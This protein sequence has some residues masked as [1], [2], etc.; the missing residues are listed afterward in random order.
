M[1]VFFPDRPQRIKSNGMVNVRGIKINHVIQPALR[2]KIKHF[3]GEFAVGVDY[4][5]SATGPDIGN[6]QVFQHR[7]F[8]D[9]GF[10]DNVKMTPAVVGFDAETAFFSPKISLGE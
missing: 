1:A 3:F 6:G 10:P 2:H 5:H 4:C 8:T 7:R 9:A